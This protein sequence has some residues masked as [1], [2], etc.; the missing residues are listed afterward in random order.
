MWIVGNLD[1]VDCGFSIKVSVRKIRTH[2]DKVRAIRM[3]MH[4]LKML[5][6]QLKQMTKTGFSNG[7]MLDEKPSA[8]VEF[9]INFPLQLRWI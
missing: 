5:T 1:A 2:L 3:N 8:C 7:R 6:M 4:I 9:L